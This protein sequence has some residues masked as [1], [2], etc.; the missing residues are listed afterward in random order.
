[1]R[2]KLTSKSVWTENPDGGVIWDTATVGLH[3]RLGARGRSY[4]CMTRVKGGRQIRPR[5]GEVGVI[6]LADARRQARDI[7][8]QADAGI[9]PK[10]VAHRVMRETK[11]KRHNTFASLKDQWIEA[12]RGGPG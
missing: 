10:K 3:I 12:P 6:K 7:I 8:H 2:T 11:R 1:M 9:D 5:L 4:Y